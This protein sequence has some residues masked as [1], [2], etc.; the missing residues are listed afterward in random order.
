MGRWIVFVFGDYVATGGMDDCVYKGN[1]FIEVVKQ[2]RESRG[3]WHND[4]AH[5][6]DCRHGEWT[7]IVL[8]EDTDD[9]IV[10]KLCTV[11]DLNCEQ[12]EKLLGGQIND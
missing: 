9:E 8:C 11:S 10:S 4:Y 7:E 6:L 5:V 2:I 3:D 1:S 12:I